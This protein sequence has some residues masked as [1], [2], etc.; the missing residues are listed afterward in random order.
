ML[1][2]EIVINLLWLKQLNVCVTN[3]FLLPENVLFLCF[4]PEPLDFGYN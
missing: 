3:V 4:S 1:I 2:F